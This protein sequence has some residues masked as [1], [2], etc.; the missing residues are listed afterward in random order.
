[1][2]GFFRGLRDYGTTRLRDIAGLRDFETSGY[3]GRCPS[4]FCVGAL[5]RRSQP[6]SGIPSPS[7]APVNRAPPT[8]RTPPSPLGL[9]EPPNA[10][11][12][13]RPVRSFACSLVRS[14]ACSLVRSFA[15]SFVRSFA[16][17]LVRSFV[18]S[19]A[20]SPVRSFARSLVR[21]FVRSFGRSKI[22]YIALSV[23]RSISPSATMLPLR[24]AL[25]I[26][27]RAASCESP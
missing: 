5:P 6:F 24:I 26:R 3:C 13:E 25:E 10:R 16:C 23:M 9:P 27:I 4:D 12:S 15:C 21:P 22:Y 20:R 8:T 17:S 1:M 19:F 18:R 7:R 11:T 2:A 14:F